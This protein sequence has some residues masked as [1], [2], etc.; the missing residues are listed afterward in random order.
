MDDAA[1]GAPTVDGLA[2]PVIA[3]ERDGRSSGRTIPVVNP[4]TDEPWIDVVA[5]DDEHIAAA[6]A[7]AQQAQREW[8][9]WAPNR[10]GD[11]LAAWSGILAEHASELAR[12]DSL[13]MG[14]PFADSAREAPGTIGRMRYW[15]GLTDKI[16][17]T[18]QSVAPGHLTYTRRDPLGVVG[19][20][21][22]WNGPISS[23]VNRVSA[24]TACGNAVVVKPSEMAPLSALRMAELAGEAGLPVGLVNVVPGDGATGASLIRHPEVAGISFTGSVATG[25]KVAA[26]AGEALKQVV[27][28]LGGKSPSIVFDDADLDEAVRGS[29]WGVF[30]NSGQACVASTRLLVQRSIMAEVIER[31]VAMGRRVV[32]GDPFDPD[33]RLGPLAFRGQ[34]DKVMDYLAVARDEGASVALGGGR[35]TGLGESRGY[36][37]APTVLVDVDPGMR[38]AQE[39]VFGPVLCVLPF[40]DEDDAV[41]LANDVEYG[42][43]AAIWTRD[44]GR[45][46]R[47]AD[48]L[49]AGTIFGNTARL[50][51][52]ALA[53]GGFKNSGV[54]N[55]SGQGAIE[56]NTRLKRVTIRYG[57]DAPSPGWDL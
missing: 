17:G 50:L 46:L 56:G 57:R 30:H 55:A 33:A 7:S 12:L 31:V 3:G 14:Y 47:M 9:S 37:V 48:G 20:I 22:P 25:R 29:V 10:R 28:E 45:M 38:V 27:L 18:E 6:V 5:G 43:S 40:D 15:A 34:Y 42:L 54:G 32:V 39:E 16:N 19:V 1:L 41:Q 13:S 53:F 52:P 21:T 2:R 44:V 35:P 51:H 23:F 36:Y 26:T 4:A 11:A 24:A 8:I 49:E